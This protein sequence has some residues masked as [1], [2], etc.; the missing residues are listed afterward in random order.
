MDQLRPDL[1]HSPCEQLITF[2]HDRPGHD[3]R[4]AI[5]NSHI[6]SSL[7]WE[8][9]ETFE[10]GLAKTV[11]WYLDNQDWCEEVMKDRYDGGRLGL[12]T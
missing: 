2:V 1:A 10:S 7:G 11:Q 5:D 4:Y 8:P 9:K 12:N 3:R 6:K